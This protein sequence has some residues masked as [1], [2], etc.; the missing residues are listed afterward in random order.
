[1]DASSPSA[2]TTDDKPAMMSKLSS[3]TS[4]ASASSCATVAMYPDTNAQ[5]VSVT[6]DMERATKLASEVVSGSYT[7]SNA[8]A[9]KS[10]PEEARSVTIGLLTLPPSTTSDAARLQRWPSIN[11]GW[12]SINS[13]ACGENESPRFSSTAAWERR[14]AWREDSRHI[15]RAEGG[16]E[17]IMAASSR[18]VSR[19][20]PSQSVE[21]RTKSIACAEVAGS[22]MAITSEAA[23]PTGDF[24]P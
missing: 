16:L 6:D 21:I 11:S 12:P 17:F 23:F 1:M 19:T 5:D 10:M 7:L 2:G 22:S 8:S 13:G 14:D 4:Y 24:F 15:A 3:S 20:R 18:G 9:D